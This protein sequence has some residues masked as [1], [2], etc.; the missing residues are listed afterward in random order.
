MSK[1]GQN[2]LQSWPFCPKSIKR[3]FLG[4]SASNFKNFNTSHLVWMRRSHW[5]Q[6]IQNPSTFGF[7]V[8]EGGGVQNLKSKCWRIWDFL[9]F[10]ASPR[11]YYMR[12]VEILEIGS[13]SAE[14][15]NKTWFS[16]PIGF[17]FQKFQHISSS[18]DEAKPW[19]PKNPKSQDFNFTSTHGWLIHSQ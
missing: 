8:L 11:P 4:Q 14:I 9:V 1:V 5:Y 16:W 6:K 18:L 10:T 17:Q 3:D 15:F 2:G 12:S 7:P 19:I 13:Q